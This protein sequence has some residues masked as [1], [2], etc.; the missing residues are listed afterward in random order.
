[1]RRHLKE[2]FP[3][4]DRRAAARLLTEAHGYLL[5]RLASLSQACVVCD[6]RLDM[7]GAKPVPCRCAALLAEIPGLCSVSSGHP[8]SAVNLCGDRGQL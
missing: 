3:P 2:A 5:Q 8:S 1:M 4:P 7:P 6:E